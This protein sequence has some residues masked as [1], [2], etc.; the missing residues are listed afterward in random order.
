MMSDSSINDPDYV[1]S[2]K[3]M[4]EGLRPRGHKSVRDGSEVQQVQDNPQEDSIWVIG[5][6][7]RRFRKIF[8]K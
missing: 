5:P 7:V 8:R 6:A 2:P 4:E 1:P 3:D